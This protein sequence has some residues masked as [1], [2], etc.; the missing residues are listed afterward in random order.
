MP[1]AI[2]QEALDAVL[3][4]HPKLND[5]GYGAARGYDYD[6]EAGHQRLRGLLG[7][8]QQCADWL[9]AQPWQSRLTSRSITSYGAKHAVERAGA[10]YVCNGALIAAALILDMPIKLEGLNPRI[11]IAG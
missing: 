2:T 8:V 4:A 9:H 11:G 6:T 7:E 10:D 3:D 5:N 1:T